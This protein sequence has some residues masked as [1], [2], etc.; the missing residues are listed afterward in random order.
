[1]K[2]VVIDSD[3]LSFAVDVIR[4][5]GLVG[6][7][8]D[9]VYGLAGNG[10]DVGAVEKIYEVKGRPAVKALILL[11]A[12][13]GVAESLC[14]GFPESARRLA[15]AFWPGSLS[16]VLRKGAV[17]PDIVTAGGDTVGVRC[18]DHPKALEL[19]RL[20]GVPLA[21]PS[22]NISGMPSP[23]SAAE[24]LHYFDGMIDCVIDGG[25][26]KTGVESTIVDLATESP[27]ILRQ[28]ALP[29]DAIWRV[30]EGCGG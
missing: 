23:K 1:M 9:T 10:L 3:D 19:M 28:G 25:V 17:V 20:A 13:I 15:D 8:T 30:L 29:E 7:P 24:V 5:G 16:L 22:A 6:V 2:T 4:R 21:A 26:C 12:D 27:R 18:P 14:D 11:V